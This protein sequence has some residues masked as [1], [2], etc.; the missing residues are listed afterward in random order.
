[1]N[2]QA[3]VFCDQRKLWASA[4]CLDASLPRNAQMILLL[5]LYHRIVFA[6]ESAVCEGFAVTVLTLNIFL[7]FIFCN[8]ALCP[9]DIISKLI[10]QP[11]LTKIHENFALQM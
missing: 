1:M 6:T 9:K 3:H 2:G 5:P 7:F 8:H 4:L 10:F 11:R